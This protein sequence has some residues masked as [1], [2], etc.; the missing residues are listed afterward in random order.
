MRLPA[1][2]LAAASLL[3]TA[4]A[5]R[6]EALEDRCNAL[7]DSQCGTRAVGECFADDAAWQALPEDCIGHVQTTIENAREAGEQARIEAA[8]DRPGLVDRLGATYG[9]SYGGVLRAGPGIGEHKL[10]SV[11]EGERIRLLERTEVVTDDYRWYR[12]MTAHGEGYQW[13]GI[14]CSDDPEALPG[15]LTVCGSEHEARLFGYDSTQ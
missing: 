15:V 9:R 5:L 12:V 1:L 3:L 10:A 11:A 4:S 2:L 7:V 14:F 13:G 6:A 8:L